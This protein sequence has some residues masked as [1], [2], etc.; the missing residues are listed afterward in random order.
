MK[1]NADVLRKER[2]MQIATTEGYIKNVKDKY[3]K[4][5]SQSFDGFYIVE[6][7]EIG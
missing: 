1:A 2:G 7:T 4:V 6:K 5:K 3:L